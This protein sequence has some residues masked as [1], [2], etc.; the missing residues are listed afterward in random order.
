MRPRILIPDLERLIHEAHSSKRFLLDELIRLGSEYRQ[1]ELPVVPPKTST[2]YMGIAIFNLT[3]LFLVTS[4]RVYL[5]EAR[6]W[7]KTVCGYDVWGYAYLVNVDL[8]ASWILFGMSFAYHYLCAHLSSSDREMVR[9]KLILQGTILF[10]YRQKTVGKGWSTQY[11]QNHNWI[12]MTGLATVARVLQDEY[13][14]AQEWI[15]VTRENFDHVYQDLADDGSD[16]EGVPYWHY[17]VLWLVVYADMMIH[18]EHVDYFES[19][20]FMKNTFQFKLAL[21]LPDL[22]QSM[23]FGDAHDYRSGHSIAIYY[24]LARAYRDG[25]AQYLGNHVFKNFYDEEQS[26]SHIKPGIRPEIG[27]A[28]LW[29]DPSVA[30][31]PIA[32]KPQTM[33]FPDLGLLSVKNHS[34]MFAIKCSKPGGNKQFHQAEKY[35]KA[36]V[37]VLGLSHHHPDN[38]HFILAK[39]NEFYAVDD[40]YNRTCHMRH[41]NV[42]T[43]HTYGADVEGVSDVY[44]ES[45]RK[46]RRDKTFDPDH[47]G[48]KVLLVKEIDGIQFYQ[49]DNAG[50][51]HHDAKMKTAKRSVITP[52]LDY[53]ILFDQ[54]ES[55]VAHQFEWHFHTDVPPMSTKTGFDVIKQAT[56]HVHSFNGDAEKKQDIQP[57]KALFTPQEP[58]DYHCITMID[59]IT[60]SPRSPRA[61]FLFLLTFS[62]LLVQATPGMLEIHLHGRK[63]RFIYPSDASLNGQS[64]IDYIRD[65]GGLTEHH[66]RIVSTEN[67][68]WLESASEDNSDETV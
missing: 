67:Q 55:E 10:D 24:R 45:I 36:G 29:Y 3:I 48:G 32:Q 50:S 30:E 51:F 39:D 42:V 46:R 61:D 34:T 43:T 53:L 14:P 59:S 49:C 57:V 4:D 1:V 6:R 25:T 31:T 40:G 54:L 16:Y 22:K 47:Y 23:N 26:E 62:D 66:Y 8:S 38:T 33:Y 28:L 15:D 18:L 37:D 63:D 35:L 58:N 68:T 11:Y 9:Q 65:A 44:G 20:P 5:D 17:G 64:V 60:V 27:F 19:S 13:P 21:T 12:N 41:H 7:M 52:N 2:T 56:L